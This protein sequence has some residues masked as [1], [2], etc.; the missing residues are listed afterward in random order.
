MEPSPSAAEPS[1]DQDIA[2]LQG[3]Y[4]LAPRWITVKFGPEKSLR[5]WEVKEDNVFGNLIDQYA[6]DF[7]QYDWTKCKAFVEKA[8]PSKMEKSL[9][10]M[11]EDNTFTIV[12]LAGN[13]IRLMAPKSAALEGLQEARQSAL[14]REDARRQAARRGLKSALTPR[15]RSLGGSPDYTFLTLRPLPHLPNSARSLAF[16]E[17]LKADPGIKAVMAKHKLVVGLLTEMDPAQHTSATHEGVTRILGL[18]R[19]QGEVIELRLRTDAYDGWRDYK[20]IRNTLCH[21]LAHNRFGPHDRNFWDLCHQIEREVEAAD[22]TRSGR[23]LSDMQFAPSREDAMDDDGGWTGE[24]YVLGGSSNTEGLSRNEI[25]ARAAER[26]QASRRHS[27]GDGSR[28]DG[29]NRTREG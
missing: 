14:S 22:W 8:R 13:T 11:P 2:E 10:K 12:H 29:S 25:L 27:N 19:N 26:R 17:R 24:T 16:L 20:T 21:E 23:T 9:L 5:D 1:S 18:N 4:H 3:D 15:I 6:I 7:P 28:E